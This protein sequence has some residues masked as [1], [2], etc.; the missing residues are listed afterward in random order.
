MTALSTTPL[1]GD[2]TRQLLLTGGFLASALLLTA[3][4]P[5]CVLPV[6]ATWAYRPRSLASD[7][8]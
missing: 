2:H 3:P 5:L 8:E 1:D 6:G 7:H 4:R